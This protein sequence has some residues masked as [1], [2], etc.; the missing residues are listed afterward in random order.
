MSIEP[1]TRREFAGAAGAG[2]AAVLLAT[3]GHPAIGA[4]GANG[5]VRLGIIGAGSRG[6]QL[7]DTF[8]E[9]KDAEIVAVCDVDDKHA[10]D[11]AERCKTRYDKAPTT[12]R[13]YRACD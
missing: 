2:G 12:S 11:T 9:Q 4:T 3:Y 13:E 5:K 8:F 7:L 1:V 10:H 6:N